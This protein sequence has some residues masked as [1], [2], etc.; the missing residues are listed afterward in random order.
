MIVEHQEYWKWRQNIVCINLEL[1]DLV[2]Y[3]IRL[4]ES[5]V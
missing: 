3:V 5:A 1:K 4:N 2:N